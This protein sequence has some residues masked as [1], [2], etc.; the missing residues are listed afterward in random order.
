[1]LHLS[2][3]LV[4]HVDT[5]TPGLVRVKLYGG[6]VDARA[7]TVRD[8]RGLVNGVRAEQ[9]ERDAFVMLDIS[10]EATRLRVDR[11]DAPPQLEIVLEKGRGDEGVADGAIEI[12]DEGE[13]GRATFT[14]DRVC[15]VCIDAGHGGRDHGKE[16][17]AGTLEK[18]VNLAIARVVRDR[19]QEELG[20]EVV[21]TRDDDRMVELVERTEI[22]NTSG[23]DLFVSIHCNAW[24]HGGTNGF[25]SYF[26]SP[27]RSES[28]RSLQRFENQAGQGAAREPRGDVEFILWDLVQNAYIEES[29]TFAEYIQREMTARLGIPSRGV[30]QASFVVLQGAKMPAVLIE[31]AFL[32]NPTEERLLVDPAF[33]RRIADGV[34]ESIRKMQDRYR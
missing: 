29:S 4:Y 31:A 12:V 23:S 32:S 9:S 24:F 11:S 30:K 18:D 3:P 16:S 5:A 34:V 13:S 19:I 26:L 6:R 21:M 2:E 27:A 20:L 1:M 28:E 10:R 7:V 14:I 22:A 33:H 15:I 17:R 25:E 8:R